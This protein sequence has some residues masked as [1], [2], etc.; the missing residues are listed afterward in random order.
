MNYKIGKGR[1]GECDDINGV[2][3]SNWIRLFILS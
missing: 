3:K 2:K 1:F